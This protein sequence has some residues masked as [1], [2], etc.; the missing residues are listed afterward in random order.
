[1][2][3]IKILV[4]EFWK[5]LERENQGLLSITINSTQHSNENEMI[6]KR[7]NFKNNENNFQFSIEQSVDVVVA[8][9]DTTNYRKKFEQEFKVFL[10]ENAEALKSLIDKRELLLKTTKDVI[11][12]VY[13]SIY[14]ESPSP[15]LSP[16]KKRGNKVNRVIKFP[17]AEYSN[18]IIEE[19][20]HTL[21]E[22]SIVMV[23][24]PQTT[25]L[26]RAIATAFADIKKIYFWDV[27]QGKD[28]L[29]EFGSDFIVKLATKQIFGNETLKLTPETF[30]K[31]NPTHVIIDLSKERNSSDE[32]QSKR[33]NLLKQWI[34]T[35]P[36]LK[37]TF[38]RFIDSVPSTATTSSSSSSSSSSPPKNSP[39]EKKENAKRPR[40]K[41]DDES[42]KKK[43]PK[44]Q[45]PRL[46]VEID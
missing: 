31:I 16:A 15:D 13:D 18:P 44:S 29:E 3:E 32:T 27:K 45:N 46:D 8:P 41:S 35:A 9:K 30:M 36:P 7:S 19:L 6:V 4:Q 20:G 22:E 39:E 28:K 33:R 14:Y 26:T 23:L 12:E 17:V 1:M 43:Q 5:K 42:A 38:A 2:E 25:P 24:G 34:D 37:F 11:D 40:N 10:D 21:N